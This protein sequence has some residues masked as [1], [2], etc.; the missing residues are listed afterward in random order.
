MKV[1]G[2]AATQLTSNPYRDRY[3]LFSSVGACVCYE[4][5]DEDPNYSDRRSLSYIAV[6]AAPR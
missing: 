6:V 5:I 4:T 1:S 3:P 2:G